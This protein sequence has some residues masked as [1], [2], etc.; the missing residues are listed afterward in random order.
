M[1]ARS[2]FINSVS[3]IRNGWCS[4]LDNLYY[5]LVLILNVDVHMVGTKKMLFFIFLKCD[6]VAKNNTE[7]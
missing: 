1:I 4:Q 5:V 7:K 2:L 3:S 6:S